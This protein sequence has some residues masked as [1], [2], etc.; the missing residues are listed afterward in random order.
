MLEVKIKGTRGN[1]SAQYEFDAG[2]GITAIVGP[3]GAGK[4]S[5]LRVI[6]GLDHPVSGTISLGGVAMPEKAEHRQIGMVFQEPRLLPH[7]TVQQNIE[8]GR[9]GVIS[10]SQ[11]AVQ[12]GISDLIE[13]FPHSLSGGEKQ[14]VMIGRALFGAPRL[15]LFDEPLSAIDPRLKADLLT[16]I[17]THFAQANIPVLYVT[18]QMEE[19]AQLAQNLIAID[20]G[21]IV[22]QGPL[23]QTMAQLDGPA[24]F[25][26]GITSLL[27][28][29]VAAID[30]EFDLATIGVGAQHVDLPRKALNVGDQVRLRIWARDVL[31]SKERLKGVSARNQLQG[32]IE[33]IRSFDRSQADVLVRV[34]GEIVR[35]RVM[36]KTIAD[37]QMV[38]GQSTYVVFKSAS[39]E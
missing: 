4:T 29:T 12:L 20:Q 18:H 24:F 3:S 17:R 1:P 26:N 23:A 32:E 27:S 36:A 14:R 9:S 33:T 19:A 11:L 5:L 34:E 39:V 35:A 10:A 2:P 15:M 28:G 21:K 22:A 7:Y 25:E 8:L 16:L 13:R 30:T 31:L 38:V 37:L 6:A